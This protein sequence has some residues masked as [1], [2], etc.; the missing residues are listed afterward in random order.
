M[1]LKNLLDQI[2]A[3]RIKVY[4][5]LT[6][7]LDAARSNFEL[8]IS[9]TYFY[10]INQT[11]VATVR[12]NEI[13]SDEIDIIKSRQI[14]IPFYRLYITNTAQAGLS[15]TLAIGVSSDIFSIQDYSAPD[16]VAMAVLVQQ[17]RDSLAYNY[18]TQIAK[19]NL[20]SDAAT[21][22][23]HTVTTGKTLILEHYSI[24]VFGSG[25]AGLLFITNAS[26]VVQYVIIN[27]Q[28]QAAT[29]FGESSS[30]CLSIPEGYKIKISSSLAGFWI[31]AF[32]KG[33]E[34]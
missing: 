22:I 12:F 30:C 13:L 10:V 21:T 31:W 9:G 8:T 2:K 26:D 23:I 16:I 24:S 14:V 19:S 3:Q 25:G 6:F 1:D 20:A 32:I 17:L 18:G 7:P 4:S 5:I 28:I 29:N 27:L 34:I 15:M 11:G 33:R